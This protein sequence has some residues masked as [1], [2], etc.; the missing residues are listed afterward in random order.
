MIIIIVVVVVPFP[1]FFPNS[2]R[3]KLEEIRAKRDSIFRFDFRS[4][5]V[6]NIKGN[7]IP[8]VTV[9]KSSKTRQAVARDLFIT[10]VC[11]V[12]RFDL[13]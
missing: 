4:D 5:H 7:T 8:R 2:I 6:S 9:G 12:L 1:L 10:A 11:Y 13:R 3:V